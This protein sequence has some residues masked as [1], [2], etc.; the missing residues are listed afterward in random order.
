MQR[1]QHVRFIFNPNCAKLG[2]VGLL[3]QELKLVWPNASTF[4]CSCFFFETLPSIGS[5]SMPILPSDWQL[6]WVSPCWVQ[7]VLA[8]A[9]GLWPKSS[10]LHRGVDGT[11]LVQKP[12][13]EPP[14]ESDCIYGEY[15]SVSL[16]YWQLV[17][18]CN[19]NLVERRCIFPGYSVVPCHWDICAVTVSWDFQ[20]ALM[21][22]CCWPVCCPYKQLLHVGFSDGLLHNVLEVSWCQ[23]DSKWQSHL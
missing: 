3:Q 6:K 2:W 17:S 15:H 8:G 14:Y 13:Q 23:L 19:Q 10:A 11:Y 4:P 1:G 22:C 20:G 9:C 7:T 12:Q 16:K 18:H 5:T 21:R